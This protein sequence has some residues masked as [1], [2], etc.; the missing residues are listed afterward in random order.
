MSSAVTMHIS[1]KH[2]LL[3]LG[4]WEY[5]KMTTLIAINDRH[6]EQRRSTNLFVL[7]IVLESK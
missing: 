6:Y 7:N 3:L 4:I 1:A 5:F 2:L